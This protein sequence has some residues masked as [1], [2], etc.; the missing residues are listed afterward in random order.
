MKKIIT[1]LVV[2][3]YITTVQAQ[4]FKDLPREQQE[5]IGLYAEFL[6]V[7]KPAFNDN[8]LIPCQDTSK[9]ND[10][11]CKLVDKIFS[12]KK[13]IQ[14]KLLILP[15]SRT[16]LRQKMSE[17]FDELADLEMLRI[18]YCLK[19]TLDQIEAFNLLSEKPS[20]YKEQ[21]VII[22]N[23]IKLFQENITVLGK[24]RKKFLQAKQKLLQE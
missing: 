13:N 12:Q 21:I 11:I 8:S 9:K 19:M 20:K 16:E 15:K 23:N 5:T 17:V 10:T 14:E 22:K 6:D 1:A 24:E 3:I 7:I 2:M 4:D 18:E